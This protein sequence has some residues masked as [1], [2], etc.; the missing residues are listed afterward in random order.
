MVARQS[1]E[2]CFTAQVANLATVLT[3]SSI[4]YYGC[5]VRNFLRYLR[6]NYP[7]VQ[8]LSALRRTPHLE[9]WFRSLCKHRSPLRNSTLVRY[10]VGERRTSD[11]QRPSLGNSTRRS[12]II[13]IRRLLDDLSDEHSIQQGLILS[14]D[15]PPVNHYLPK[16]LSPEDDTLLQ[17][18]LCRKDDLLSNALLLLRASGLRIGE[19]LNL[20]LD[21]LRHLGDEQWALH[22]PL[23][24]LHTER[25]VP[26]DDHILQIH[27]RLLQ[28]RQDHQAAASSPRLLPRSNSHYAAYLVL[29]DALTKDAQ[30]AGC[31]KRITP[32]QLRH[33]YATEMLR[34]GMSLPGIMQLLGHK[35]IHMTLRYTQ[36]SQTDLQRQYHLARKNSPRLYSMPTLDVPKAETNA[37]I[38]AIT[39]SL[40][41][42][43]H[44]LEMHRRQLRDQPARRKFLRLQNRLS[45]IAAELQ[46]LSTTVK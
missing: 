40:A 23:G 28:L 37:G 2:E 19:L 15:L 7:E 22:V 4:S 9:G 17:L 33:T 10:G 24:K 41:A 29:R 30:A 35:T 8:T 42:T 25:L 43:R 16:P 45:K 34:A 21:C 31:P 26:V 1:L 5:A 38:P 11:Q 6:S 3:P 32:H 46:R 44:L 18:Y 12:Y 27:S 39:R 36:V 13:Y 14:D 20:P